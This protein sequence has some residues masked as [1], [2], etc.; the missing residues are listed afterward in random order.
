MRIRDWSSDV[1]SSD[2]GRAC[3]SEGM[4]SVLVTGGAGYIG[5]HAVLA[6]KDAGHAV[7]VIDNLVTGLRWAVPEGRSEER[8][9]GKGCGS[10]GRSRWSPVHA[11]NKLRQEIAGVATSEKKYKTYN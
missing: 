5:S 7:S 9:V 10:T 1:C 6:L 3:G 2:L 11:H 8:R 4:A